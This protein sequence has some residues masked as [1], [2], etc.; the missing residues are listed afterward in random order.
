ML[1]FRFQC[2][3]EAIDIDL[4]KRFDDGGSAITVNRSRIDA[5]MG[6]ND[7]LLDDRVLLGDARWCMPHGFDLQLIVGRR[8]RYARILTVVA[9]NRLD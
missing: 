1:V 5:S 8:M 7:G 4:T 9:S 3:V 6:E 2:Y